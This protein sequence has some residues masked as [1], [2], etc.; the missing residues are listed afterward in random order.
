MAT[1]TTPAWSNFDALSSKL[2]QGPAK[3][4]ID[5]N[6]TARYLFASA[7]TIPVAYEQC[8]TMRWTGPEANHFELARCRMGRLMCNDLAVNGIDRAILSNSLHTI[9]ALS[10]SRRER[11]DRM[12][13]HISGGIQR[14]KSTSSLWP[15]TG[16]SAVA[17][18]LL[19]SAS[20][21]SSD[22]KSGSSAAVQTL[23]FST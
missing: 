9:R 3:I 15:L 11:N 1:Q 7:R 16:V 8:R 13:C 19:V 17:L 6:N 20:D 10:L 5:M 2:Q 23:V 21:S 4:E 14:T 18:P 12:C 22:S